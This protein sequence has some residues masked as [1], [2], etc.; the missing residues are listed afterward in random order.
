MQARLERFPIEVLQILKDDQ[1]LVD[2]G[3]KL[4]LV[5]VFTGVAETA[6]D[7]GV[8]D[9]LQKD[10]ALGRI[11]DHLLHLDLIALQRQLGELGYLI[12]SLGRQLSPK[13][14]HVNRKGHLPL[15]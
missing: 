5:A 9:V 2:R 6:L 12:G 1:L 14:F 15:I 3:R 8:R 11:G 10:E 13:S 7:E 4:G